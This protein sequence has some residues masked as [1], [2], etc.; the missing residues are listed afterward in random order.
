LIDQDNF[1]TKDDDRSCMDGEMD[2][3]GWRLLLMVSD[4]TPLCFLALL[5]M[6]IWKGLEDG[7]W[8]VKIACELAW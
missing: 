8:M 4:T 2:D 7:M 1:N 5:L 3:F 6:L